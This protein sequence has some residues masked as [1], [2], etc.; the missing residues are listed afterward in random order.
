MRQIR[1][2]IDVDAPGGLELNG[3]SCAETARLLAGPSDSWVVRS[4][5]RLHE[6]PH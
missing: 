1:R 5:L 3:G 2:A 4:G 6:P